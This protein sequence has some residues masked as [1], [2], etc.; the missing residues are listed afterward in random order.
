VKA[1]VYDR[2][3]PANVLQVKEVARPSPAGDEVLVRVYASTVNRTDVGLRSA[4]LFISRF[5]TGLV[6]PKVEYQ[7][8]GM[9]FSGEVEDVGRDVTE[10]AR[11]DRVFGIRQ[12]ANAEFVCVRE[13]GVIAPMPDGMTF[14]QGAAVPDGALAAMV[15]LRT[16]A[17]RPGQRVVVY[18]A[19]GSIGTAAV[20]VAKALG[21]QVTAVC[22]TKNVELARS[23]G[24]DDVFDFEREDFTRNGQTYDV[25]LDAVGKHSFRRSRRSLAPGGVFA[26]T[27]LGFMWHVPLFALGTRWFGDRRVKMVIVRYSKED[28][29]R[30]KELVERGDYRPVIDRSYPVEDVVEASRYV[31]TGQKTGNVVLIMSG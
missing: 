25:I 27:D 28:L 6:R 10:F 4:Q 30:L 5:V 7:G 19:S 11:G 9:E 13:S 8:V 17:V 18:G 21:A 14:E 12:G 1:V 15:A 22:N 2:Y 16:A 24:A 23:L 29:L 20:Q 31:E 26:D 3:G